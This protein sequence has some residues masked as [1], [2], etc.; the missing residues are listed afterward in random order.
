MEMIKNNT[1]CFFTQQV[2]LI[3]TYNE[4]RN[5]RFAP[6]SWISYT[7]GEPSCLVISINGTK[8]TKENIGRTGFLSAT[9]VT[10]DLLPLCEQF[11]RATYK[12][13]MKDK[14][15]Y[16][17]EKGKI[18]DVPLLVGG[19]FSYECQVIKTVEIGT[20]HTYF[21]EIKNIN[22]SEDIQKLDFFDLREVNPVVYS[23]MNY[24]TI[25]KHL[26]KIGDYSN[27]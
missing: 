8:K 2:F 5:E 14:L 27:L 11:N 20:T 12:K 24:F 18:L 9:V 7:R 19:K 10:P 3:G 17:V 15:Q 13:E 25:G 1:P 21:A 6:I 4:D 23:P 26:G 22:V 16:S